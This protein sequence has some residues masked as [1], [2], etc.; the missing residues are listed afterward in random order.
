MSS[1]G[2]LGNGSG[3]SAGLGAGLRNVSAGSNLSS[4]YYNGAG[5]AGG[6]R[7]QSE[8]IGGLASGV[9][10]KEHQMAEGTC[11]G[12]LGYASS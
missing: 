3:L 6:L 4:G 8:Y 10:G 12:K 11:S 9:F 1:S 2:Y 7:P 5:M